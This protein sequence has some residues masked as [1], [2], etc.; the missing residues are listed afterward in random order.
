MH[1]K[2]SNG[3]GEDANFFLQIIMKFNY[4]KEFS[5]YKKNKKFDIE[6]LKQ[7]VL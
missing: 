3:R 5:K 6:N 7:L 2:N 4:C 1:W